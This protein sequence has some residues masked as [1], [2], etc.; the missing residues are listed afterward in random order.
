MILKDTIEINASAEKV[1][2]WLLQHM[3]DKASYQA[4]HPEHKELRW[5]KG[6]PCKEGSIVYIEE[7][8]QGVLHK[9]KFR[10]TKIIPNRLIKYRVLFPLSIIAPYNKFIIE[11]TGE[12]S[13]MFTA[14]GKINMP[15][16]LFLKS[17]KYHKEKLEATMLHMKGEGENLKKALEQ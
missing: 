15:K 10:F 13:C 11:P 1:F 2:E 3:R 6:E 14:M 5:I 12:N 4:W 17:H 7:Y 9:L 16:W 8:L